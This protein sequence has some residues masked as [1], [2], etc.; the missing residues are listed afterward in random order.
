M[1]KA[2]RVLRTPFGS[3][4]L[5]GAVVAA[6]G[7]IAIAAGWIQSEGGSTTTVAAPLTAPVADKSSDDGD[8]NVVNQ[9]YKN[10]GDG[11]AFIESRIPAQES[12]SPSRPSANPNPK[13]AAPR[14][15][16]A[17]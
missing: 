10:D 3:A 16:P 17:S 13:A 7:W 11:V 5:G 8:T 1:T 6:F 4:L 2:R 15:A 9:I 14:P 12:Q